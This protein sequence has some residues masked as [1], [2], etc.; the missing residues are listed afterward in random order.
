MENLK[1]VTEGKGGCYILMSPDFSGCKLDETNEL[2]S[3][4]EVI[5]F[6]FEKTIEGYGDSSTHHKEDEAHISAFKNFVENIYKK[7]EERSVPYILVK[8][9]YDAYGAANWGI[10]AKYQLLVKTKK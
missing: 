6:G 9:T 10:K 3:P 5:L 7:A 4:G 2:L 8:I 1:I